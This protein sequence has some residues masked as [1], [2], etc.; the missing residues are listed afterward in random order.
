MRFYTNPKGLTK[1]PYILLH[2]RQRR[3][4]LR[5]QFEHAIIDSG[6]MI[7]VQRNIKEYPKSFMKPYGF[8]A[9]QFTEIYG[10]KVWTVIPDY[11]DDYNPGQF[12][13]NIEKTLRNIKDFIAFEDVNWLPVIQSRYKNRFSYLHSCKKTKEIIGDYPQIAIGTVCKCNELSFIEY[14]AKA[15]RK[16]FPKSWIHAF[17]L[18]L[19]ALPK[20]KD[21]IDSFDSM[22]WTFPRTLGHSAKNNKEM[23]QYFQAYLNRINEILTEEP[24]LLEREQP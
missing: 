5:M 12:G 17:G 11:P 20:V 6:V 3:K 4:L 14:C 13:D 1:Y 15:T 21:Y 10:K 22:A 7:F 8:W 19:R 16:T 2:M 18:T 24:K 9:K 23:K